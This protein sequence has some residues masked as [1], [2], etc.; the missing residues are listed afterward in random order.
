MEKNYLQLIETLKKRFEENMVRHADIKWDKVEEKLLNNL[1]KLKSLDEM[2]QTGGE[3]DVVGYDNKIDVYI[4]VDCSKESPK[5]RRSLCYDNEALQSRKTFKPKDSAINLAKK[6]GVEILTEEQYK[7]LQKLGE[8]DTKSQSWL[9]TPGEVRI[10]GG[11]IFGDR[12][13][14]HVFVYHNGAESYYAVRGFRGCLR[15]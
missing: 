7:E 10:L 5:Y 13:Y 8:F 9:Q 1:D 4:F 14:N 12:R 3:P 2:E 6:L 15:V 11:A